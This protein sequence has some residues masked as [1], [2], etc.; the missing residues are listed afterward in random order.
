MGKLS[1]K[2]NYER[3]GR[4][5]LHPNVIRLNKNGV[6]IDARETT[7]PQH[8]NVEVISWRQ[9]LTR[10]GHNQ[11]V[12]LAKTVLSQA[13]LVVHPMPPNADVA[14]IRTWGTDI[15]S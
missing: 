7:M 8:E 3:P 13:C 4:E 15:S 14:I 6:P 2:G 1:G 12:E 9:W 5:Q 10:H 11:R